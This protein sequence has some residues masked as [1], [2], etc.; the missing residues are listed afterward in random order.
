MLFGNFGGADLRWIGNE[1][2]KTS[3]PCWCGFHDRW[4]EEDPAGLELLRRGDPA[5]AK[6]KPA[7][8]DVSIRQD[9]HWFHRDGDKPI[10]LEWLVRIWKDSV[11]RGLG[12][13]LNLP[14]TREGLIS[15]ADAARLREMRA[16]TDRLLGPALA[17]AEIGP[18]GG[19]ALALPRDR[20]ARGVWI[21]EDVRSGQ[22]VAQFEVQHR[23]AGAEGWTAVAAGFTVGRRR[24]LDLPPLRGGT[25]R[26]RVLAS[27]GAPRV[28][29][30]RAV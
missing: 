15:G 23:P 12:L 8:V 26:L 7:E 5:G 10:P 13:V 9:T 29:S 22:R 27:A 14:P 17:E 28:S 6:W 2:G 30:F 4:A 21:E 1:A 25:L 3:D 19:V 16:E 24:F 18:C 11:G 20:A